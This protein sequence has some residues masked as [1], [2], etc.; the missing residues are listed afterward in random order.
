MTSGVRTIDG[1]LLATNAWSARRFSSRPQNDPAGDHTSGCRRPRAIALSASP[2]FIAFIE[3]KTRLPATCS[4][5]ALNFATAALR[6]SSFSGETTKDSCWAP[7][8]AGVEALGGVNPTSAAA[9]AAATARR[10]DRGDDD[11]RDGGEDGEDRTGL[12]GQRSARM[13][14]HA[15]ATRAQCPSN[16]GA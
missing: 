12:H 14:A 2:E 3:T 9:T 13:F 8:G 5:E 10:D 6:S 16:R 4:P 7:A 15:A 11:G 1:L